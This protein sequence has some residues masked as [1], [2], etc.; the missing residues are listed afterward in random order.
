MLEF[1]NLIGLL[2][3]FT[4]NSPQLLNLPAFKQQ[5][6]FF[7]VHCQLLILHYS[8]PV[9]SAPPSAAGKL[10]TKPDYEQKAFRKN[11]TS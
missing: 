3:L 7:T 2:Q 1:M 8:R 10:E 11:I 4:F 5:P 6:P 9:Q